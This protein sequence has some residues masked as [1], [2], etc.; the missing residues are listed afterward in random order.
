MLGNYGQSGQQQGQPTLIAGLRDRYRMQPAMGGQ[1]RSLAGVPMMP[2][3]GGSGVPM[4]SAELPQQEDPMAKMQG[5]AQIVGDYN[6]KHGDPNNPGPFAKGIK[7]FLNNLTGTEPT[8]PVVP[9]VPGAQ[10]P[11]FLPSATGVPPAAGAAAGAAA[12]GV[13]ATL[14]EKMS[15]LG[16]LFALFGGGGF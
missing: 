10:T 4:P 8:A 9:G 7:G 14:G 2:Q 16:Q 15:G 5:M 3:Q 11:P 13:P 12:G 6:Q 1:V